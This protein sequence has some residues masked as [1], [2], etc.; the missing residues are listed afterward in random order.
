MTFR[1]NDK[2]NWKRPTSQCAFWCISS[3]YKV[4]YVHT[5]RDIRYIHVFVSN[6][7]NRM[8]SDKYITKIKRV[9]FFET[10]CSY[11]KYHAIAAIHVTNTQIY[12]LY[13]TYRNILYSVLCGI[14][15]WHG[16]KP[17]LIMTLSATIKLII[18]NYKKTIHLY[19]HSIIQYKQ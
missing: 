18:V 15:L 10:Q 2:T 9:T 17:Q 14:R 13:N 16:N 1:F 8:K 7:Q 19:P 4:Q 11:Y 12:Y 6:Q 5:K 3:F